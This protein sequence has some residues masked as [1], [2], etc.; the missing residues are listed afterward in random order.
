MIS[1][2]DRAT[3]PLMIVLKDLSRV[4]GSTTIIENLR[5]TIDA[6]DFVCFLGPSGCGKS[7]LLRLIA[8]LDVPTAGSIE[9]VP[10]RKGFVFQDG[11]LLPWKSALENVTL[12]E[13]LLAPAADRSPKDRAQRARSLL[14]Q[15]GLKGH[16][17]KFPQ[18]LS[19]GM[20]MRVSVA[21]ALF[22]EPDLLLLDEP[23]SAL[24][25]T[26]RFRLQEE[27]RALWFRRRFTAILVTHSVQ[28]AVF[29]SNRIFFFSPKGGKILREW[30][31]NGPDDRGGAFRN[32]PATIALTEEIRSQ[33]GDRE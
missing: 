4:F 26:I 21:R 23:F 25:E 29:L 2:R 30:I 24:D 11:A 6:G 9:G 17:D 27:F 20:R 33:I 19:G 13:E 28:E 10:Q 16:E 12:S 14:D 32:L 18:E 22:S 3:L 7:T 8:G 5:S 15:L 1:E 31:V